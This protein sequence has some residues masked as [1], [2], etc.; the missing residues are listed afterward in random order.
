MGW[1][2]FL[3]NGHDGFFAPTVNFRNEIKTVLR[4]KLNMKDLT[5][6]L[7]MDF[8]GGFRRFEGCF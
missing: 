3:E 4:L 6:V 1:K 7:F 8:P 5:I 2:A